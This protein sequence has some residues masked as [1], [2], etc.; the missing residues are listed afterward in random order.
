MAAEGRFVRVLGGRRRG[1]WP[2]LRG[3][4][5]RAARSLLSWPLVLLLAIIGSS[6]EATAAPP[7]VD[8][9]LTLSAGV[10][11]FDFGLG[12]GHVGG[13]ANVSAAGANAELVVG[14][15]SR[16]ELGV[17]TGA[18]FGGPAERAV[19]SDQYGRLYD[20]QT[21]GTGSEIFA[22]PE[23]RV[24]GALVRGE[25]VELAL[26]G[27]LVAPFESGTRAGAMFGMPL[28]FHLGD[29]VRLDTGV[30]VPVVFTD[31]DAQVDLR[32]PLDLWIQA[33][34]RV[35]VG[36]MTGVVITDAGRTVSH[37]EL[38]L[39]VGMGVQVTH[40]VD[41]KSMV[42]F[43]SVNRNGGRDFGAGV[44]VELRVE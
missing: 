10:W 6:R 17:R 19:R 30:Y 26:E 29:R 21:F 23:V 13:D 20:R 1:L 40:A 25:V 34:Q 35:W 28:A 27:R 31:P 15:T 22:N 18:R 3:D 4:R 33:S 12:A 43:P 16:L 9:H 38:S 8:R 42:L 36:P 32:L 24:R 5:A 44:G 39:G 11:A 41:F 37:T 14:L 7:W 2:A